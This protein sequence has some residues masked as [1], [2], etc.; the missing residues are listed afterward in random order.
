MKP[1]AD[2]VMVVYLSLAGTAL[3]SQLECLDHLTR[4]VHVVL[5]VVHVH[6]AATAAEPDLVRIGEGIIAMQPEKVS[7]PVLK[8]GISHGTHAQV[9]MAHIIK[10]Q[11]MTRIIIVNLLG[12]QALW[13]VVRQ[14]LGH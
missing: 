12:R 2:I 3:V 1:L 13:R 7:D 9:A 14:A 11:T 5:A 4:E 6:T 10:T 8:L